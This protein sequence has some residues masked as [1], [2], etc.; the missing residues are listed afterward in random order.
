[1][2]RRPPAILTMLVPLSLTGCL[3]ARPA[4]A[5]VGDLALDLAGRRVAIESASGSTLAAW[6][7]EGSA[8]CGAMLLLHGVG[9]NRLAMLP[10]ARF[11]QRAGF[12]ILMPDFQAHGE[13]S[14]EHITFGDRERLDARAA[15][16][17]LRRAVPEE[18]VGIIGVSMGG[19]ALLAG[20]DTTRADA[21]VLES[22]YPTIGLAVEHRF[23]VWLG[24]A[25]DLAPLLARVTLG[26]AA[27]RVGVDPSALRPID[28]IAS[29]SA[30]MLILGG[31]T[32]PYT[33]PSETR[34]LFARA[35]AG[36]ELWIV[37]GAGHDD[38]YAFDA[39]RYE[40]RVG[41]FLA[42][43]LQAGRCTVR[44]NTATMAR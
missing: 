17:F 40:A 13:S 42:S 25:G 2:M 11:L 19:A 5:R 21:V 44:P 37:D 26:L 34:A 7:I 22:V 9:D 14:G 41:R 1:M 43:H 27:P 24:P 6:M 31:A 4:P 30:P 10:R 16:A 8:G 23:A 15:L 39:P 28:R 12:A 32:D 20:R 29:L 38:L 33:P 35:A 36:S 18:R 3:L